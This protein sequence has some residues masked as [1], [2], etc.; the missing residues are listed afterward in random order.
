MRLFLLT[1]LVLLSGW[2][3][4]SLAAD[5]GQLS[6]VRDD[7][8]Y[9]AEADF[10]VN[11]PVDEV[12][13]AFTDYDRLP[14]LNASIV[15]SEPEIQH[16][17]AVRVRTR[18]RTCITFFC[19][20]MTIIERVTQDSG[21]LIQAEIIPEGSDFSEGLTTW[22]FTADEHQT[23]VKYRS[24]I[25]PNFWMPPRLGSR[26]IQTSLKKQ[27]RTTTTNIEASTGH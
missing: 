13:V 23:R 18:I 14:D 26:A 10:V 20:S 6:V 12:V 17:G 16:D 19:R 1:V 24:R 7:Q 4:A 2:P 22:A 11:M 27:I 25:K 5:I 15:E 9:I 3:A 8:A 21:H